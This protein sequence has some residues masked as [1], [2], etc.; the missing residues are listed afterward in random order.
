MK[1]FTKDDMATRE[2]IQIMSKI[3]QDLRD[4]I[5]DQVLRRSQASRWHPDSMTCITETI[6]GGNIKLLDEQ[7]ISENSCGKSVANSLNSPE[8]GERGGLDQELDSDDGG[9]SIDL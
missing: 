7:H 8:T 9:V 5:I 1:A 6:S 4:Q 2:Q 3:T